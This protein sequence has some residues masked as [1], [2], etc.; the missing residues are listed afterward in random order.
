MQF[1]W[2]P[3]RDDF[4]ADIRELRSLAADEAGRRLRVLATS[5]L[6]VGQV[7]RLDKAYRNLVAASGGSLPGLEP[8]RVAL[9][10]S[11]TTSHLPAGLRV[12]G[13]RLGLAIEVYE[14]A[15]GM[16][17]QELMDADAG[18]GLRA[19][20]PEVV[21]LAL[22]ARHLAGTQGATVDGALALM[23]SCWEKARDLFKCQVIQ[24]TVMPILPELMGSNEERM[25]SSPAAIV[26][27][28][29]RQ[30][31]A[32][33]ASEGVDLLTMDPLIVQEGL[34]HWYD[35][36][37]W[38]R[39]KHEVHPRAAALYGE[40]VARLMA[41]ARGRSAKCLVLDLD[42]TLWGGVIGD[43]GLEGIV[44]GQG[45]EA[46]EAHAELQRY[47]LRLTER[48]VILAVC[49]K[50]DE[51][52][53]LAP[54]TSHPEMVLRRDHIACFVANWNDKATNLRTI[55]KQLNIGLDALVFVDDNPAE[56]AIVRQELPMVHV[57]ELSEEPA[58]YVSTLAAAGYFEA[59]RLTEDDRARATQYQENAERERLRE[60][61]TDMDSYLRSLRMVLT[62]GEFD[63]MNLQRI[64][65]LI[66]KT[67]QFNVMTER[68]SEAEVV[69]RMNDRRWLTL[70]A[71]LADRFGDN[72]LIAILMARVEGDEAVIE[73]WLMSCRVL[74]RG[75]EEACLNLLAAMAKRA[76]AERLVGQYR[77]TAKNGM[78]KTLYPKLGFAELSN[79]QDE[80]LHFALNLRTFEAR[81]VWMEIHESAGAM[82]EQ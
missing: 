69:D 11:A 67:N 54:F 41:A 62:A 49:S 18:N 8:V 25:P 63:T 29:N 32:I 16:Y 2:L 24:Q 81:R 77:A 36:A 46:G 74:G 45:S 19:F 73:S 26:A 34:V 21:V 52:N 6:D 58:S 30:L 65:Q 10:G 17:W 40:H 15:Y 56:R 28:I 79:P 66:N 23:Q 55:A 27:E 9:L 39:S 80:V 48:G 7:A 61:A 12:A 75:V 53:A 43:D 71:R 68:L 20:Q 57:P 42:N 22:D 64:T 51:A 72:G 76:G 31:P 78:V 1:S 14:A 33:A 3:W 4:D 44:L 50:N 37:M 82:V 47:A 59:I 70:H 38:Y 35:P 13:L 60:T 5:R